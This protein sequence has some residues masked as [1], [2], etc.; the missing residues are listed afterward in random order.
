MLKIINKVRQ[1][2]ESRQEDHSNAR[3]SVADPW[4][5]GVDPDTDLDPRIHASDW[6]IR[7]R[8]RIRMRIRILLF[9]SLTFK[10]P[11][12]FFQQIFFAYYFLKVLIKK[13]KSKRSHEAVEIK[14][15]LTIF[16]VVIE[17][18]GSG[19]KTCGPGGSGSATLARIFIVLKMNWEEIHFSNS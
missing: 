1:A 10:M 14:A 18:S 15:F 2:K 8:L 12:I 19:P 5:F 16:G 4:Y 11:T 9:S 7:I 13:K 3:I 17:G 6:C